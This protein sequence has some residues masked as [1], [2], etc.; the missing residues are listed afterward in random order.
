MRSDGITHVVLNDLAAAW[1][2]PVF[3]L[4]GFTTI[5]LLHIPLM[6]AGEG[7]SGHSR[8]AYHFI[9]SCVRWGGDKVLNVSLDNRF[10]APDKTVFVGTSSPSASSGLPSAR[11]A[12]T[13]ASSAGFPGKRTSSSCFASSPRA[14][15]ATA[16][17]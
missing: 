6:V 3:R 5:P 15:R 4:A 10:I 16:A 11:R 1:L 13:S 2:A 12:T 14:A 9:K 8:F 17:T 7:R